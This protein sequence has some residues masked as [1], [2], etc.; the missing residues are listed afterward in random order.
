MPNLLMV[1]GSDSYGLKKDFIGWGGLGSPGMAGNE[2]IHNK[3]VRDMTA[4]HYARLGCWIEAIFHCPF[5]LM[6]LIVMERT[7]VSSDGM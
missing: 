4:F 2:A 6:G 3:F 7:G 5:R 1:V